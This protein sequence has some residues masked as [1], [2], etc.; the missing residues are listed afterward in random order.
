MEQ[1]RSQDKQITVNVNIGL[2]SAG[3]LLHGHNVLIT[4]AT[5]GI[6]SCIAK[7]CAKQGAHVILVDRNCEK[8]DE[9]CSELGSLAS[10]VC[11]DL[12]KVSEFDFLLN[13]AHHFYGDIDC[14]VNNVG[15]SLHEGDFMNVTEK[16]WDL[17]FNTNLK[18][19]YFLT[20]SWMRYY[21]KKQMKSGRIV[22]MASDTSGMGSTIPYGLSKAGISSFTY[23]LAKKL[24]TEGIRVNAM[25]PGTTL[26]PMTDDFTH[27]EVC[28]ATTQGKRA[29]F[30]DEIG[31]LCVF[32]LSDLS[33]CVSGNIFGCSEANI[34]FN[35]ID[36]EQETN[37]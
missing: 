37:P 28:R 19:P 27:G 8:L 23:G 7:Q 30:P 18:I 35:N 2:L 5:G 29:L 26:T 13:T 16:N 15:I 25:A 10:Q 24:I 36:R 3:K 34:C 17:Q 4:G 9:L 33:A 21:R 12:Q 14:L 20:Q 6:G 31:Q 11:M 32:L 22:M 1:Y